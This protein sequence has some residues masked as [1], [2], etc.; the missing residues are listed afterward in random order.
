MRKGPAWKYQS[1][2]VS[3]HTKRIAD[4]RNSD[5]S[6]CGLVTYETEMAYAN[7]GVFSEMLYRPAFALAMTRR[8]SLTSV[9]AYVSRMAVKSL[10][11]SM[12]MALS[13]PPD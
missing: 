10:A 4:G 2:T 13:I 9:G 5:L 6:P 7:A 8:C 1:S 11:S 12:S 3:R